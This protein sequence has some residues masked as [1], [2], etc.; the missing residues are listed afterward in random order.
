[1]PNQPPPRRPVPRPEG[2]PRASSEQGAKT[3]D[4]E[5]LRRG[6]TRPQDE[7]T[8]WVDSEPVAGDA[9]Q[10]A[11]RP[12]TASRAA[13]EEPDT[14]AETPSAKRSQSPAAGTI[15]IEGK[16]FKITMPH[17][18]LVAVL[19]TLGTWFGK[20]AITKG[21]HA[22]VA[23]VLHEVRGLRNDVKGLKSD[24]ADVAEEQRKGR[25]ADK[26]VLNFAEDSLTPIVASLRR[27]GVKLLYDSRT[28]YDPAGEI[29]FHPAPAPGSTAPPVQ[30]KATLPERP[31][32]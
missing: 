24:V 2:L 12:G 11:A 21:E 16:G 26:K 29:E 30:P 14:K 15:R 31:A 13:E 3:G 4:P 1:M 20:D 22:E 27:L 18:A 25:A 7:P 32:L 28:G 6:A 23:D 9:R 10:G 19:T 17:V 5:P 8:T